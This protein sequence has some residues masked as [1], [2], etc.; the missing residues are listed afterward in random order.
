MNREVPVRRGEDNGRR[1][2]NVTE[3]EM[4]RGLAYSWGFAGAAVWFL[5]RSSRISDHAA[6]AYQMG[7]VSVLRE[8]VRVLYGRM[9]SGDARRGVR[10]QLSAGWR[11]GRVTVQGMRA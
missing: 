2:D 8:T 9:L 11:A 7:R 6:R 4:A 3:S 10:R 5:R 1:H